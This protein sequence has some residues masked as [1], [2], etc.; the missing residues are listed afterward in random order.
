MALPPAPSSADTPSFGY[1]TTKVSICPLYPTT[2]VILKRPVSNNL[3]SQAAVLRRQGIPN[4]VVSNLSPLALLIFI[5]LND[6]FLYHALRKAGIRFTP[7]RK[8]TAGFF[9]GCEAMI[10]AAVVQYS[11]YQKSVCGYHASGSMLDKAGE[12]AKCPAPEISV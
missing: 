4:E 9:V 3:I 5:P 10:W 7:I 12:T 6:F 2:P 1:A 8:I 11:I